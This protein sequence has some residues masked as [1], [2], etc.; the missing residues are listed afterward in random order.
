MELKKEYENAK[1]R[2]LLLHC[3]E[4]ALYEDLGWTEAEIKNFM[5]AM[6]CDFDDKINKVNTPNDDI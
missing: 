1:R 6:E 4:M 2:A 3:I 5:H